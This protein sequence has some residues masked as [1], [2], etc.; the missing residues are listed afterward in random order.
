MGETRIDASYWYCAECQQVYM[1]T[2]CEDTPLQCLECRTDDDEPVTMTAVVVLPV[3]EAARLRRLAEAVKSDELA[4]KVYANTAPG[5]D[6]L[7]A[8]RAALKARMEGK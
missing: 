5:F 7:P 6:P 1:E 3:A 2:G 4:W 8:F